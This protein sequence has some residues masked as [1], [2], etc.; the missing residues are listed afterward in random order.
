MDGFMQAAAYLPGSLR[1]ALAKLPQ[2]V[3]AGIQEIRLRAGAPVML[4]AF[5]GEWMVNSDGTGICRDT[6]DPL[7]CTKPQIEE[8]FMMLCEYSVHTHQHEISCGFVTAR[9]GCR[10]GIAGTAVVENGRVISYR[11][12]TSICIRVA[13]RHSG[14]AAELLS[15]VSSGSD[16]KSALICGEPSSGK[17]SL[18]KDLAWQLSA[19]KGGRRW[20]AAVVDER[21]E[22]SGGAKLKYCDVLSG[23]PKAAGIQQAIRCLAPD[24]VIFDELGT[25]KETRAVLEGLNSGVF[26]ISSAHCR[27]ES[28]LLRRPPLVLALESGA[29]ELVVFLKGRGS[30]GEISRVVKAGDILAENNRLDTGV[31]SRDICR[32]DGLFVPAP[33]RNVV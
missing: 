15:V 11:N 29:F 18:L 3:R 8:C 31:F 24:V 30:P 5:D 19:G 21:G 13:R 23:C 32:A 22:L 4:S 17:T 20:R 28:S 33:A 14:C 26:A 9:C 10:A 25:S 12:I 1:N 16:I 27:D 7:V 6:E 2:R